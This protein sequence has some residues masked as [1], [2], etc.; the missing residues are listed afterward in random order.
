MSAFI[1]CAVASCLAASAP[2]GS[3][4]HPADAGPGGPVPLADSVVIE[5][6]AH[7]LTLFHLGRPIRQYRVALGAD[8]EKDKVSAGDRRTP[9]GMFFVESKNSNS[10]FHLALK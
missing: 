9:T 5:K 6:K 4:M 2:H 8:P 7:R 3:A 10:D 1:L